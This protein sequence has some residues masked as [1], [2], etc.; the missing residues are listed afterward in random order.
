MSSQNEFEGIPTHGS[1]SSQDKILFYA[2][3]FLYKPKL[4]SEFLNYP[5]NLT[6]FEGRSTRVD[7]AEA[8]L[9]D[10]ATITKVSEFISMSDDKQREA[11]L[12]VSLLV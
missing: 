5:P 6:S 3:V 9:V 1:A 10:K 2:S 4:K 12:D 8:K 7:A 11:L